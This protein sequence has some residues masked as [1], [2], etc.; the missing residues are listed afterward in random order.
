MVIL[1]LLSM[2]LIMVM[3]RTARNLVSRV[4]SPHHGLRCNPAGFRVNL[5]VHWALSSQ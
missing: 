3:E 1:L 2:I 5:H 4:F